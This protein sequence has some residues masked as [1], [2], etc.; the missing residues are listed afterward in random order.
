[1]T[2]ELKFQIDPP[3]WSRDAAR[4]Q[5]MTSLGVGCLREHSWEKYSKQI[6]VND[7]G[8][9]ISINL[10]EDNVCVERYDG[11]LEKGYELKKFIVLK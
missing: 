4:S 3:S 11:M 7:M 6:I 8:V 1:M 9:Y 2:V 5:A 10:Y